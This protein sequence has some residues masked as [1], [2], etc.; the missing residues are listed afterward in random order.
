[1]KPMFKAPGIMRLKLE[2]DDLLS[3]FAFKFNLRRFN[4]EQLA[5]FELQAAVLVRPKP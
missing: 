1:M 5:A 3:S 4:A 2:Y